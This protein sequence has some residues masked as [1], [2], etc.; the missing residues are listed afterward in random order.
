MKIAK[1][2]EGE[3]SPPKKPTKNPCFLTKAGG[4]T[5]FNSKIY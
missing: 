2:E 1:N 3:K 4:Q 5:I